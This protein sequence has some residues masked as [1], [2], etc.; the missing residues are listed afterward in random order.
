MSPDPG[1]TLPPVAPDVLA[2]A[3]ESLTSR[4]RKKLDA[5]VEQYATL[6]VTAA[7]GAAQPSAAARTRSS[8]SPPAPTAP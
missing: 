4:L 5:A 2:A 8:P 6:P 1:P 7:E 3:V